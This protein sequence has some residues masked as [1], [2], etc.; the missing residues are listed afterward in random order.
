MSL[1]KIR[2]Y[3]NRKGLKS[4]MTGIFIRGEDRDRNKKGK[5]SNVMM[6]AKTKL[7]DKSNKHHC[8]HAWSCPNLCYP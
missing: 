7:M 5:D 1:A 4:N 6:E 2:S 3:W 8:M